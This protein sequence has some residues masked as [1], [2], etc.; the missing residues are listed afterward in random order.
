ML[1]DF[2]VFLIFIIGFE[3]RNLHLKG[4]QRHKSFSTATFQESPHGLEFLINL[5]KLLMLR[6]FSMALLCNNTRKT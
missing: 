1:Q 4:L 3:G 2:N 5:S 6:Y